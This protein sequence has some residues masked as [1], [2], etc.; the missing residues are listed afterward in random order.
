MALLALVTVT[1]PQPAQAADRAYT[2][3]WPSLAGYSVP[4]WFRDAKF[5]IFMHWGVQSLPAAANDGWYARQMYLQTGA[6]WGR[7]YEHHVATYG[8][9]SVFGFKDLIPH[10]KAEHWDPD[11]LVKFYQEIGARYIVPVAVHH[12]NFD[13]YDSKFQPW[14]SVNLGPKRDIVREWRDAAVRHGLHFGVSSHADRSWDW[15]DPAHG[16]DTTGPL[17]GVPYDGNLTKADGK[18]KWW[19]GYDPADLYGPPHAKQEPNELGPFADSAKY[20]AQRLAFM[21]KWFARTQQLID[22]YQPDLLYFDSPMPLAGYGLRTAAHFYNTNPNAVLNI[23]VWEP[24][25]VPDES[26]IVLDIEKG[27]SD[28]LRPFPWQTDTSLNNNWF[29]DSLP[30]ELTDEMVVHNLA[31]IVSKNG[32]LMLNVSLRPDG[33]L[34]DDQRQTLTNV[35]AWLKQNGEAIY[36]TRPWHTAAEG[37]TLVTGGDFKQP[38]NAFTAAD[39]RFTTKGDTLYAILMGWPSDR[40]ARIKSLT[41]AARIELVGSTEKLTWENSATG[42]TVHL[43]TQPV[44]RFAYVLKITGAESLLAPTNLL[45]WCIVP[46]DRLNRTPADRLA[47]LRRLGFS[48]YAWD[49]RQQHLKDLPEEIKLSREAGVQLRAVWLWVDDKTDRPGLLND[50]NRAVINAVVQAKLSVEYWVGFNANFFDGLD[51]AARVKKAA[52]MVS[53]LRAQAL[54]T[55]STVNLYNHGDWFGEPENQLKVI[56]AAGDRALGL[57][58]NFHHGHSQIARFPALLPRMLPYLRVVNLDGLRPEGP[59]ILPLGTGTAERG[60]IKLLQSSGYQGAIG[61]LGHTEGEDVELVLRR[62]LDGL[63]QIQESR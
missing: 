13:L 5:G 22:D 49:W 57:I 18:G 46:Y 44:G 51:D 43:P 17:Q 21:E 59:M 42:V 50:A 39:L 34:P 56:A 15:F 36:G 29:I 47:M 1:V 3:D 24:G 8:H 41:A 14:N 54:I 63:R 62:N 38:T 52:A 58:Y 28:R 12:D 20:R 30:A 55:G 31:D 48:Q 45:A 6:Q 11:A 2:P 4:A 61:I 35:G 10:W 25:T 60:M 53:Y 19:E 16:A 26:A 33:T 23:K 27:Q 7:A 9:P 37:P 40:I 32:N